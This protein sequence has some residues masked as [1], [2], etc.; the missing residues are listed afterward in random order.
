MSARQ[1]MWNWRSKHT[2]FERWR[3][4]LNAITLAELRLAKGHKVLDIG[5]GTGPSFAALSAA[6]GPTGRVLGIDDNAS[7]IERAR[8]RVERH[9]WTNVD[10]LHADAAT[11]SLDQGSW[12]AANASF[13]VSATTDV[14]GTVATVYNALRPGGRFFVSDMRLIPKGPAAPVIRLL[15]LIY[16]MT[17]GWTGVDVLEHLKCTFDRVDAVT[18]T[19]ARLDRLP[20]WPPLILAVASKRDSAPVEIVEIGQDHISS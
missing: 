6:V 8:Q 11:I 14:P 10:V 12:D 1:R 4:E 7:M 18:P 2:A 5:C 16:R 15:R 9:G 17:A 20:S 3:P 13:S 19:G